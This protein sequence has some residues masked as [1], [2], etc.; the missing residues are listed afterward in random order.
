LVPT[1]ASLGCSTPGPH[2]HVVGRDN[3]NQARA[4]S[5]DRVVPVRA[6]VLSCYDRYL[7]ERAACPAA[8]GCDFVLVNLAHQPFGQPMTTDSVRKWLAVLSTRAG[9]E[10]RVTPHMFRHATATELLARSASIDVVKRRRS[11]RCRERQSRRGT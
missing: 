3:P 5:G 6:E 4:K 10:R 9:L 11:R 1:A 8:E 2:V 7:T